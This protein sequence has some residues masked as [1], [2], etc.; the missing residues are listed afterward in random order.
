MLATEHNA[1]IHFVVT[2]AVILLAWRFVSNG[3]AFALLITSIVIVWVAEAFNTVLEIMADLMVQ[4]RFSKT[5]KRAKDISAA[6]VLI[7]TIGAILVGFMVLGP[8]LLER[9]RSSSL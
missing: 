7:A 8:A 6:A 2:I 4:E 1:R 9:I 5:V 3:I